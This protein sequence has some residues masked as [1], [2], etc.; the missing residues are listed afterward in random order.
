MS[1]LLPIKNNPG[2]ELTKQVQF[3]YT[4]F[5]RHAEDSLNNYLIASRVLTY[6]ILAGNH[7][8]LTEQTFAVEINPLTESN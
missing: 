4:M 8:E 7:H 2:H 5:S 6:I 3:E 1:F